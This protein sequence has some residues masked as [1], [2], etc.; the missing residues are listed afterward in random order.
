MRR[1]GWRR[2][3]RGWRGQGRPGGG[4]GRR[5]WRA[6][7]TPYIGTLATSSNFSYAIP[8]PTYIARHRRHRA[9]RCVRFGRPAD[10][11]QM[12]A[13]ES[14][15]GRGPQHPPRLLR[16]SLI[17]SKNFSEKFPVRFPARTPSS[18]SLVQSLPALSLVQK[19]QKGE[20]ICMVIVIMSRV[21]ALFF[22]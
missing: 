5:T 18:S 14:R 20:P 3:R 17:P 2:G 6:P 9:R 12:A 1:A 13:W 19:G 21:K 8:V 11:I 4:F 15:E 16:R 7:A 22:L 10:G